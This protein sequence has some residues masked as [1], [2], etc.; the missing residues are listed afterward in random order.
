MRLWD[1]CQPNCRSNQWQLQFKQSDKG[2][3]LN[4]CGF[5]ASKSLFLLWN[6]TEILLEKDQNLPCIPVSLCT[7]FREI[8]VLIQDSVA[9]W[10][11][12][13]G[14]CIFGLLLSVWNF[15]L[16]FTF[17]WSFCHQKAPAAF[18]FTAIEIA[19]QREPQFQFWNLSNLLQTKRQRIPWLC[20]RKGCVSV[21]EK[22]LDSAL[23]WSKSH[24]WN[25]VILL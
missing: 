13:K 6:Y 25:N 5:L 14:F 21:L 19:Q 3:L 16:N 4:N 12:L 11:V 20:S 9:S 22:P 15:W 23:V 10:C 2:S 18:A 8:E 24:L 1:H 7:H 17:G